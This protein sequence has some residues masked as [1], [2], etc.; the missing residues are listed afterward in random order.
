MHRLGLFQ[1][2]DRASSHVKPT[3]R[4]STMFLSLVF[5]QLWS[6]LIG[7][8][9]FLSMNIGVLGH[10]PQPNAQQLGDLLSQ[11]RQH[12]RGKGPCF[13]SSLLALAIHR[14]SAGPAAGAVRLTLVR[15]FKI[16][17]VAATSSLLSPRA[18]ASR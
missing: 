14:G 16:S 6:R 5:V 2:P 10:Q 8:G 11:Q 12:A 15:A 13:R 4:L 3:S 7:F 18:N 1:Q 17:N 9:Q